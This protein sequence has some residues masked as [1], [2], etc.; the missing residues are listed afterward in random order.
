MIKYIKKHMFLFILLAVLVGGWLYYFPLQRILAEQ[1]YKSYAAQQGISVTDIATKHTFKDYKQG[2]YFI[3][4]TYHKDPVHRYKY[5]YF[6]FDYRRTGT[7]LNT[8]YCSIFKGSKQV[9]DYADVVFP[10]LQ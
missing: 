1:K 6:L 10:P 2:G 7:R 4:V 3:I 5:Q 8:M 9:S